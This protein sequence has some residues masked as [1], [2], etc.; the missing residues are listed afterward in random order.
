[1]LR[2]WCLP[3]IPILTREQIKALGLREVKCEKFVVE[4]FELMPMKLP[5]TLLL[6][7][8]YKFEDK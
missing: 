5:T 3:R 7:L 2:G 6:Y 8:D 1:M 4:H